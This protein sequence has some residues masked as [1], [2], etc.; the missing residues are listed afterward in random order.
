MTFDFWRVLL[1]LQ[2]HHLLV[3][4]TSGA[5]LGLGQVMLSLLHDPAAAD[6]L[7]TIH[8]CTDLWEA[9]YRRIVDDLVIAIP[10]FCFFQ[11]SVHLSP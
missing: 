5:A 7:R 10:R 8:A 1:K 2:I 6:A 11:H 3:L 9:C 4:G